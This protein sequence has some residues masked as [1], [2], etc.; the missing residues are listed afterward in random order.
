MYKP[1]WIIAAACTCMFNPSQAQTLMSTV[2]ISPT[3]NLYNYS[4]A[5]G[6]GANHTMCLAACPNYETEYLISGG[7]SSTGR[8]E[9]G[10][11]ALIFSFRTGNEPSP[12]W[13]CRYFQQTNP[14]FDIWAQAICQKK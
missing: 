2:P 11:V 8:T 5:G 12:V 6:E 13:M 1:G 10:P 9:N 3:M 4:C 14:P 7:C